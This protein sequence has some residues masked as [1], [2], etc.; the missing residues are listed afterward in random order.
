MEVSVSFRPSVG[1]LDWIP[2]TQLFKHPSGV[3]KWVWEKLK[4]CF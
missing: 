2:G 3:L 4:L 1:D